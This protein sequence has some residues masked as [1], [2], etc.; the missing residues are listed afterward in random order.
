MC[1]APEHPAIPAL[2]ALYREAFGEA[3][4]RVAAVRGDGSERA[5][6]RVFGASRSVIG[7]HGANLAENRAFIGFTRAFHAAGLPVPEL[8]AASGDGACYLEEDL[9]DLTL[10]DW[11]LGRRLREEFPSDVQAMYERVLADLVRF[12]VRGA[13]AVDYRLCYQTAEFGREAMLADVEYFRA[14]FLEQL[15]PGE[16]DAA[17]FTEET[18]RL[19][20]VLAG[21][22]RPCFLYRDFQSR[23][24]LLHR[25]RPAY[26][27]YQSG[28]RGAPQYDAASLLYDSYAGIPPQRRD[29]LLRAYLRELGAAMPVDERRFLHLYGGFAALRVMQALGAFGNL[30]IRKRKRWF[31]ASIPPAVENLAHLAAHAPLLREYP[32]LR[33]LFTGIASSPGRW[34]ALHAEDGPHG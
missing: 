32:Y 3:A 34:A 19:V 8:Y 25:G 27:D 5:I 4:D 16:C 6:F 1:A 24:I 23:N 7:V 11:Q 30:G 9:G 14:M 17:R 21:E 20:E 13:G 10:G 2:R 12:Q 29:E 18:A 33:S 31:L 22:P 26:I 15:A 28:R